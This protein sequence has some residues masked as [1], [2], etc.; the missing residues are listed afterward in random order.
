MLDTVDSG[1]SEHC[2]ALIAHKLSRLNINV[3]AVS[4][5]RLHEEGSLE[6]HGA[7]YT[8]YLSADPAE[9]GTFYTDLSHLTQK[10]PADDKIII[11][12][13]FNARVGKNSEV[14]KGVLGKH[15]VGTCNDSGCFLVEFCAEQQLTITNTLSAE[16]QAED[17]LDA[18]SIQALAPH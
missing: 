7:G 10:V 17:N 8:L 9:K 12:G 5:V 4:E 16:R 14:W 2:S 13:D 3:A 1:H 11:L 18:S 15:G 6:E